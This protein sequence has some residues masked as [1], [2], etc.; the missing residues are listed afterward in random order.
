MSE[1]IRTALAHRTAGCDAEVADAVQRLVLA[2]A[3]AVDF[4]EFDAVA[5]L[6][7]ADAVWDGTEFGFG[8]HERCEAIATA[9]REQCTGARAIVHFTG[10]SLVWQDGA[11]RAGG[12]VYFSALR[13]DEAGVSRQ[14]F[15]VYE[16]G[17]VRHDGTWR[18]ALRTLRFRLAGR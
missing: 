7:D 16:D 1:H 4:G 3:M 2:Y 13:R 17:Y 9:L 5:E 8:R 14:A 11:D 10:P 15:G 18:F 6:F 12:V